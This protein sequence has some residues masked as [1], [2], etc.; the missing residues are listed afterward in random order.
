MSKQKNHIKFVMHPL[1]KGFYMLHDH[2]GV[3]MKNTQVLNQKLF[4]VKTSKHLLKQVVQ[5]VAI[6]K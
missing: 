1:Y 2:S 3:F 4:C 6:G 5:R